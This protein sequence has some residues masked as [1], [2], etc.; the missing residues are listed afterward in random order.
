MADQPTLFVSGASG[1]MGRRVVELLLERGAGG[2]LI[3]GSRTPAKL[4]GIA[5][6]ETR[7]ADFD[8]PTISPPRCAAS[9]ACS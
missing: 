2:R 4:A 5:G 9:T 1:K 3:A 6:V 8:D 7:H